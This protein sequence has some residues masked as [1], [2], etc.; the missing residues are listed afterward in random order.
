[1]ATPEEESYAIRFCAK[2][3]LR[4]KVYELKRY[5]LKCVDSSTKIQIFSEQYAHQFANKLVK[6]Y[7][8]KIISKHVEESM[9]NPLKKNK[10]TL[11]S[12][13]KITKY[14]KK[15]IKKEA[16]SILHKQENENDSM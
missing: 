14:C 7:L 12:I 13:Q 5:A 4:S 16:Q 11:K 15:K 9:D 6:K 1:M 10:Q 8:V 3:E 2:Q